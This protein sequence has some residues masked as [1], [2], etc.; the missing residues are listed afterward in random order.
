LAFAG[1]PAYFLAA[2]AAVYVSSGFFSFT[3]VWASESYPMELRATATNI[4]F[5]VGRLLGGFSPMLV[6]VL[7]PSSL[8]VGLGMSGAISAALALAGVAIYVLAG[9]MRHEAPL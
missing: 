7:Y 3:G 1:A 6:I 5:L 9:R 8:R 4:V 2:L